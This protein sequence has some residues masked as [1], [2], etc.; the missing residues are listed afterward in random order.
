MESEGLV[1]LPPELVH[2]IALEGYLEVG[3]VRALALT[4][5]RMAGILVEDA[6]GRDLHFALQGV[7]VNV[8]AKR[9]RSARFAVGRMWLGRRDGTAEEVW[10]RVVETVHPVFGVRMVKL[11][12]EEDVMGW[13]EVVLAALA[14]CDADV[15]DGVWSMKTKRLRMVLLCMAASVGAMRL[16]VWG[17]ERGLDVDRAMFEGT[18]LIIASQRGD[19]PMVRYL[20]E[21][22]GADLDAKRGRESLLGVASKYGR[23]DVVRLLLGE[24]GVRVEGDALLLAAKTGFVDVVRVLMDDGWGGDLDE[25]CG[26]EALV[27]ASRGGWVDV[28]RLLLE[29]GVDAE[30]GDRGG[31]ETPLIAASRMGRDEVVRILVDEGG[32]SVDAGDEFGYTPLCVACIGGRAGVVSVLLERGANVKVVPATGSSVMDL[33]SKS[34]DQAVVDVLEAWLGSGHGRGG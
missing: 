20:V 3:D 33:A 34:G 31:G 28:V 17:L 14:L 6:Y 30:G 1:G 24:Y 11:E 13:E 26:G 9:W 23:T 16:L 29:Y 8:R 25:G 32:A 27:V 22:G 10:K 19:I 21:E 5:R 7:V 2:A 4:C 15:G 18:A 12:K